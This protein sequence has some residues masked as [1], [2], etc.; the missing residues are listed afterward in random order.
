MLRPS[1]ITAAVALLCTGAM[2]Q[3][4]EKSQ[5]RPITGTIKHAGVY[6][7][8]TG[9]WT[10]GGSLA[11]VTGPST[12][13]NNSCALVYYTRVITGEVI[14]HR[15]RLPSPT[16][17]RKN[18]VYYGTTNTNHRFDEK[19]G[20]RVDYLVNGFQVAYC[21]QHIGTI[22]WQYDFADLY[23]VCGAGDM[24]PAVANGSLL[25][26]G[27][28]GASATAFA[29][30]LVDVDVSGLSGGGFT[31]KADGDGTY[32]N[33]GTGDQFGW[34]FGLSTAG[35]PV[36]LADFTGPF[37][38]GDY[39]WTGGPGTVYTGNYP[40]GIP[41]CTG[42]D[43]TIWDNPINL[44]ESGTGML[45]NDFFRETGTSTT[46][47]AGPGCYFFGGI[48]H[49]DFYLKLFSA[50][51]S[52][53]NPMVGFCFP[54]LSGVITCPCGNPPSSA[55][56]G[57]N[58]FAPAG[59]TGGAHLDGSGTASVSSDSLSLDISTTLKQIHVVFVGSK[60]TANV[61]T[62]AGVRCVTSGLN[63]NG[64]TFLKRILKGTPAPATP[65]NISFTG[66]EA[67]SIA[68]G[69]PPISGETYYYYAAYR[70]A[71]ANGAPGCPGFTF[72]FNA[73]NAGAVTWS[74]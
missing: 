13:Y 66:I 40:G 44:G 27:M 18:S 5:L 35:P 16:G 38:A 39:T 29:C 3:Q 48:I 59:G 53:K 26:T 11:N 17:P 54:G 57:C 55:T 67:I 25:V 32:N 49:A 52:C 70:N 15:S 2:A 1:L 62:G 43:G 68:K 61:R 69:A 20:C 19:E 45:S 10:R 37:I 23:T 36:A 41:P 34:S 22:D 63:P 14:Q 12:I 28:P 46:A 7:V 33:G 6:H 4:V 24:G 31:L 60:N 9:T 8:A 51:A 73:T 47:S 21:S 72:G 64:Q 42:T 65:N 71:A 58:N 50:Q 56:R 30:W 74:P